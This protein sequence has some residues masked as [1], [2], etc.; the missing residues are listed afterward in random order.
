M[1]DKFCLR[2]CVSLRTLAYQE[3][4][5]DI[6]GWKEGGRKR[7][8]IPIWDEEAIIRRI[9]MVENKGVFLPSRT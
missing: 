6:R 5:K 1:G 7:Y 4:R 8:G 9:I 3:D 2:L